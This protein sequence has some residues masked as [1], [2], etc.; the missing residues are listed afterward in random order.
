MQG[1]GVPSPAHTW[2]GRPGGCGLPSKPL[3]GLDARPQHVLPLDHI[4]MFPD[5][6]PVVRQYEL[7]AFV[8]PHH[9]HVLQEVLHVLRAQLRETTKVRPAGQEPPD[10]APYSRRAQAANREHLL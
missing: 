8:D 10:P 1:P 2:P 3:L 6:L 9:G 5:E 4:W 7:P